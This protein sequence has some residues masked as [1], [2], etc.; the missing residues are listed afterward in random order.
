MPGKVERTPVLFLLDTEASIKVLSLEEV[1]TTASGTLAD[2]LTLQFLGRIVAS[3]NL[4][5]VPFEAVF[6]V[7]DI[8]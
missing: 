1:R 7:G 8:E 2:G 4:R 5:Q 6:Y 3:G